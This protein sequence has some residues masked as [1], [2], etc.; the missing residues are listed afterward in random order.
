MIALLR[1]CVNLVNAV[2]RKSMTSIRLVYCTTGSREEAFAIARAVVGEHLAAC[3]NIVDNMTSV[4]RWENRI[5]EEPETVLWLKTTASGVT[6]L[7]RRIKELHSYE[8]PC[9]VALPVVDGFPDYLSWVEEET[10][11]ED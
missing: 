10:S 2:K 6:P 1:A 5:H 11:R 3:A 8:C 4:Y 9:I 7:M